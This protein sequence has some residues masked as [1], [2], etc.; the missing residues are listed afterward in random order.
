MT[1]KFTSLLRSWIPLAIAVTLLCGIIYIV[2]QQVYRMSANDPQIQI[3][4]D[5]AIALGD[6]LPPSALITDI[7]V[8]MAAS[9]S[10]YLI[11]FDETGKLIASSVALDGNTPLPP[12]GIFE[13]TRQHKQDRITWQPKPGVRHAAVI[14]YFNGKQSGFVLAGRSMREVEDR[15]DNL[16]LGIVIGWFITLAASLIAVI[17]MEYLAVSSRNPD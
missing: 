8:N 9:L 1:I 17:V 3:A 2:A 7:P 16:G 12:A 6:G 11:I 13:Y 4:E 15:I 14:S 10:P 5:S